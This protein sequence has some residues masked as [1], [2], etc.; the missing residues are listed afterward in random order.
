[1]MRGS[2]NDHLEPWIEISI[3]DR[4][5]ESN[6]V[7]AILD[8]G[9]NGFLT[10]QTA[11]LLDM[12]VECSGQARVTLADGNEIVS[13]LFI[14]MVLWDGQWITIDVEA[15]DTDPLIGMALLRGYDVRLR[16]EPGAKFSSPMNETDCSRIAKFVANGL[17]F[18]A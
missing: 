10:S 8:T 4:H 16:V 17:V 18:V 3:Q 14:A 5:R 7:Q 9:F 2:V 1:M 6:L 11:W 15:A 12:D 13:D